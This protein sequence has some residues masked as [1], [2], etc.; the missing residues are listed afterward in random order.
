MSRPP[1]L[2]ALDTRAKSVRDLVTESI[3]RNKR[4]HDREYAQREAQWAEKV[5]HART[6]VAVLLA[7]LGGETTVTR[8]ELDTAKE[9]TAT[10]DKNQ[11]ATILRLNADHAT[12]RKPSS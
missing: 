2:S 4:K 6:V 10:W 3:R 11:H 1:S 12:K 5:D 7:K 8:R 9:Y